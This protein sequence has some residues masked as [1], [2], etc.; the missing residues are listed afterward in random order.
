[1]PVANALLVKTATFPVSATV[2]SVVPPSA[3]VTDP[4]GLRPLTVA[5][6]V[7]GKPK[8]KLGADTVRVISVTDLAT[9]KFWLRGLAGA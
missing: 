5:V 6:S 3:K 8:L 2:A 9:L 7:S 1:M 4:V